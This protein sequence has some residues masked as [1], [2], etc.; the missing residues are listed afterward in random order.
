MNTTRLAAVMA[1][2][3]LL[4]GCATTAPKPDA[5]ETAN[6]KAEPEL[7]QI[8]GSRIP[9]SAE[10]AEGGSAATVSPLYVVD[11]DELWNTGATSVSGALGHLPFVNIHR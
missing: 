10:H 4:A 9:Q 8:T 11:R 5:A 6:A 3:A 2:G 7:V 1:L